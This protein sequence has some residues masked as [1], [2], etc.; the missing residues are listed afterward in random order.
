MKARITDGCIGC[1]LCEAECPE[2]FRMSDNGVAEVHADVTAG[3]AAKAKAAAESCPV[4][5]IEISE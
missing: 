2:V 5:C 4:P 1:G 3:L